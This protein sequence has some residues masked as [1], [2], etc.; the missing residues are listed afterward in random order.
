MQTFFL[1]LSIVLLVIFYRQIILILFSPLIWFVSLSTKKLGGIIKPGKKLSE[2]VRNRIICLVKAY[3]D[4]ILLYW[5]GHTHHHQFKMFF[6]RHIYHM[7]IAK[8][9]VIYKDCEVRNPEAISIGE[10]SIIGDNAILDGRA[11]LTIGKNVVLA[12]NVSIWTLQHD[13][14]DPEFRCLEGHYGPVHICDRAWIGPNAIILH[15]V[16]IGEG[17]VVAA[18]AVVTKNVSPFTLVAGIPAKKI[19]ERSRNLTYVFD[20]SH[21]PFI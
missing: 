15:N 11:G 12:S 19:G 20:G 3:Q 2:R 5:V 1:S 4:G 18:G 8:K 21:R 17:A 6:Y 13:Y 14:R 7:D 9:V 16:T 10:G